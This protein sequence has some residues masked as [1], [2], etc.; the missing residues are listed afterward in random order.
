MKEIIVFKIAKR[1][2]ERERRGIEKNLFM[3]IEFVI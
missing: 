2:K 1:K 3:I